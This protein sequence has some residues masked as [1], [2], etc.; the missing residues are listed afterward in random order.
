MSPSASSVALRLLAEVSDCLSQR[1]RLNTGKGK[2]GSLTEIGA[3]AEVLSVWREETSAVLCSSACGEEG[4]EVK[5]D[6]LKR[7]R[8]GRG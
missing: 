2:A 6:E 7:K 8:V 1:G 4:E 5:Q 3:W